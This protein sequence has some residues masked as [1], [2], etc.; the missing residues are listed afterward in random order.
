MITHCGM[1]KHNK[2]MELSKKK[3]SSS[4]ATISQV[5]GNINESIDSGFFCQRMFKSKLKMSDYISFIFLLLLT[6][7]TACLVSI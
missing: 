4:C 3:C 1:S 6:Q 7:R 2:T 5:L